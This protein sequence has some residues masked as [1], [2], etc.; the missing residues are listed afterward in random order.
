MPPQAQHSNQGS[1]DG[2]KYSNTLLTTTILAEVD[3]C[4]LSL[5]LPTPP[6]SSVKTLLIGHRYRERHRSLSSPR[7]GLIP[8]RDRGRTRGSEKVTHSQTRTVLKCRSHAQLGQ[9]SQ[10]VVGPGKVHYTC[11]HSKRPNDLPVLDR[12]DITDLL[13]QCE[14]TPVFVDVWSYSHPAPLPR[15]K[16]HLFTN[17]PAPVLSGINWNGRTQSD[18]PGESLTFSAPAQSLGTTTEDNTPKLITQVG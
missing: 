16:V 15:C 3:H 5:Q 7:E 17:N 2:I 4:H 13:L 6:D 18:S 1:R 11:P 12:E 10:P 8:R 14:P 9:R